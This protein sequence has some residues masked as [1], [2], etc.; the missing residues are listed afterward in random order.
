MIMQAELPGTGSGG[1][2]LLV[3]GKLMEPPKAGLADSELR[4]ESVWSEKASWHCSWQA[5]R[6]EIGPDP[7]VRDLRITYR[8]QGESRP[9]LTMYFLP[10]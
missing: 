9:G 5:W 2:L 8:A 6:A 10:R 7:N 1:I 3:G 4:L